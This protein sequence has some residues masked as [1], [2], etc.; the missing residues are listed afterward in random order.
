MSIYVIKS[1]T[2]HNKVAGM[3]NALVVLELCNRKGGFVSF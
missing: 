2:K 3:S 1:F